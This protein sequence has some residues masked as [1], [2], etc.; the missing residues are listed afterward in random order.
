MTARTTDRPNNGGMRAEVVELQSFSEQRIEPDCEHFGACGGCQLQ[1]WD[2]AAYQAWKQARV[3]DAVEKA[4]GDVSSVLPL[5]GVPSGQ[6]PSSASLLPKWKTTR[7][8]PSVF[9][10]RS[11]HRV[12]PIDGCL[13]LRPE[14]KQAVEALKPLPRIFWVWVKTARAAKS[15]QG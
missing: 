13:I 10:C 15:H 9:G 1:H 6:P 4:G 12:E 3:V 8:L 5:T 2:D 14:L 11:E 7:P